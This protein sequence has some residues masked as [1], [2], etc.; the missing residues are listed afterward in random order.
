MMKL[1]GFVLNLSG[2]PR[3][4]SPS[5]IFCSVAPVAHKQ[6]SV[7]EAGEKI[8]PSYRKMEKQAVGDMFKRKMWIDSENS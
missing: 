6:R 4:G 2:R 7:T 5:L 8:K 3:C 1:T